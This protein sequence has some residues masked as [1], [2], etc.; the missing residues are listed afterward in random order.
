MNPESIIKKKIQLY[1]SEDGNK[2]YAKY[3]RIPTPSDSMEYSR[4][5]NAFKNCVRWYAK[6]TGDK[7]Y[8]SVIA[9]KGSDV[10]LYFEDSNKKEVMRKSL[11]AA[12][13]VLP[14]EL[15]ND[16]ET[17]LQLYQYEVD[18]DSNKLKV[19]NGAIYNSTDG[20]LSDSFIKSYTY[21]KNNIHIDKNLIFTI[22]SMVI[23]DSLDDLSTVV[24]SDWV[25]LNSIDDVVRDITNLMVSDDIVDR[26]SPVNL[27]SIFSTKISS[28]VIPSLNDVYI[29]VLDIEKDTIIRDMGGYGLYEL[30]NL[31]NT[32]GSNTTKTIQISNAGG[33]LPNDR[34]TFTINESEYISEPQ[35]EP[36]YIVY[37]T[38]LGERGYKKYS[39][40]QIVDLNKKITISD[41]N[42][43]RKILLV[44]LGEYY[45]SIDDGAV[46][47]LDPDKDFRRLSDRLSKYG[48]E[49]EVHNF[50]EK[51]DRFY[52]GKIYDDIKLTNGKLIEIPLDEKVLNEISI[53]ATGGDSLHGGSIPRELYVDILTKDGNTIE[54]VVFHDYGETLSIKD[55]TNVKSLLISAKPKAT[56]N[57]VNSIEYDRYSHSAGL[58]IRLTKA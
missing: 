45:I 50:V 1:V 36:L 8:F 41:F 38:T 17:L 18:K 11:I 14:I 16:G 31:S 48:L 40:Q 5:N 34:I 22:P 19:T 55:P 51:D 35:T 39:A 47:E 52:T 23:S 30:Y 9:V 3:Y 24:P 12:T 53:T 46:L 33:K 13:P 6:I 43:Y 58:T 49:K 44:S 27:N 10:G 37:E 29:M 26:G 4:E 2:K 20:L 42:N 15:L 25:V 21:T 54:G 57:I 32:T 56:E 28:E 7:V